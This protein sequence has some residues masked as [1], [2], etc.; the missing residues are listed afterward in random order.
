MIHPGGVVDKPIRNRN[1]FRKD[2]FSFGISE[3]FRNAKMHLE[4]GPS[5]F[6]MH[7]QFPN[8]FQFPNALPISEC[9]FVFPNAFLYFRIA[10]TRDF[11]ETLLDGF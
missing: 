4:M 5:H 11:W 10:P 2:D 7:L 6:E 3:K 9:V 1:R 8:A